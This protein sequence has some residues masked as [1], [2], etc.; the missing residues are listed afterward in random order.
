ME[1]AETDFV[2]KPDKSLGEHSSYKTI[3]L[4]DNTGKLFERIIYNKF[5]PIA[6]KE[7]GPSENQ[8][9]LKEKVC[10]RYG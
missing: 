5:L 3:C 1:K 2:P 7:G 9:R 8:F 10:D 6:E 4:L